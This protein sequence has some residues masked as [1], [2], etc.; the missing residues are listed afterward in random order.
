MKFASDTPTPGHKR[1][2]AASASTSASEYEPQK[3]N[4]KVNINGRKN[5]EIEVVKRSSHEFEP[6]EA[7]SR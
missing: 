5:I 4:I 3:G 1:S 6:Q 7:M 2:P